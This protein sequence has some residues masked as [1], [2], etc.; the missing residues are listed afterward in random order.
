MHQIV[1]T[2]LAK[3]HMKFLAFTVVQGHWCCYPWK[4]RQ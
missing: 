3:T 4:S 2:R 1:C